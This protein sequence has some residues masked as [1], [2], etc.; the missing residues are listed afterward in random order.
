MK[1]RTLAAILLNTL[2]SFGIYACSPEDSSFKAI[3]SDMQITECAWKAHDGQ[4]P[5]EE[6]PRNGY[7]A[8]RWEESFCAQPHCH[9]KPESSAC[10]PFFI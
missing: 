9:R 1:A 5:D 10:A 8:K 4:Q 7:F 6:F 2:I 3:F